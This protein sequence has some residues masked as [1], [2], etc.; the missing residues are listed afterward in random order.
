MVF[1]LT[2]VID[3]MTALTHTQLEAMN[4]PTVKQ[5]VQSIMTVSSMTQR[6]PFHVL[7]QALLGSNDQGIYFLRN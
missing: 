6:L 3:F 1:C 5:N 4:N 2:R 7:I